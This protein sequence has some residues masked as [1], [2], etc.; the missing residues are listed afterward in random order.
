MRIARLVKDHWA[1][2]AGHD[3]PTGRMDRCML[4]WLGEE[5]VSADYGY[6]AWDR[7]R[8]V[9]IMRYNVYSSVE[10]CAAGTFVLEEY[11]KAGLAKALWSRALRRPWSLVYVDTISEAGAGL[12]S[13]VVKPICDARGIAL[14]WND[15]RY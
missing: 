9:A 7:G 5:T 2:S 1:L 3:E 14:H 8:I 12:V 10:L 13:R 11:R 15:M 6:A 4:E